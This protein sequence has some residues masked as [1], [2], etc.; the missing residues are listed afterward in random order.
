LRMV[1]ALRTESSKTDERWSRSVSC[2]K[3][4]DAYRLLPVFGLQVPLPDLSRI[5]FG[6]SAL[7]LIQSPKRITPVANISRRNEAYPSISSFSNTTHDLIKNFYLHPR[8]SLFVLIA[9]CGKADQ[10]N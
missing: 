5:L 4:D 3:R 2:A 1:G 8:Q 9:I 7:T 10:I 6:P